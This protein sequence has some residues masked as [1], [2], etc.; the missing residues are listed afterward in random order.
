MSE[1]RLNY[2]VLFQCRAKGRSPRVNSAYIPYFLWSSLELQSDAVSPNRCP[3]G[4][5]ARALL[6]LIGEPGRYI[7]WEPEGATIASVYNVSDVY[8]WRQAPISHTH[9]LTP[10]SNIFLRTASFI[11]FFP[12]CFWLPNILDPPK[13]CPQHPPRKFSSSVTRLAPLSPICVPS[14]MSKIMK[15]FDPSSRRQTTLCGLRLL[16]FPCRS[17]KY[18]HVSHV[19]LTFCNTTE[20]LGGIQL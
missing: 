11:Y 4:S 14:S 20:N 5:L 1:I 19:A 7:W 17:E 8:F 12:L 18:S 13:C 3:G 9:S 15:I 10:L 16:D 2:R 6:G